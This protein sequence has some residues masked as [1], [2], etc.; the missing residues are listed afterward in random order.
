MSGWY[1]Y[2]A[3]DWLK[4]QFYFIAVTDSDSTRTAG[5]LIAA[6]ENIRLT[7]IAC[8]KIVAIRFATKLVLCSIPRGTNGWIL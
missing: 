7:F 1:D 2:F 8:V 5:T 3:N 4:S 6:T